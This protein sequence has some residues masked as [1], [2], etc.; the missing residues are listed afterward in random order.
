MIFYS[1][2]LDLNHGVA[3]PTL[4][5]HEDTAHYAKHGTIDDLVYSC[6]YD[7]IE[8][9][10]KFTNKYDYH[11]AGI[12]YTCTFEHGCMTSGKSASLVNSC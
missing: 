1:D 10:M 5:C 6:F 4:L 9:S 8:P 3:P 7:D 2:Y 11:L 12:Y